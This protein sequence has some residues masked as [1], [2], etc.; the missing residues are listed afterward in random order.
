MTDVARV[1]ASWGIECHLVSQMLGDSNFEV[2]ENVSL[3][4]IE[5]G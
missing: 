1:E 2:V 3:V 4:V 5:G